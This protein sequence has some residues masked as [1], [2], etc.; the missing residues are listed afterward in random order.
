MRYKF[1]KDE[2]TSS[3]DAKNQIINVRKTRD[4]VKLVS[5]FYKVAPFPNYNGMETK[6]DLVQTIM[7][8][9]FMLELKKQIGYN[10]KI[11][12]VG[13][14][15]SQ[16][17]LALAIGTNNE[18]IAL[19]PT[20]ESLKLGHQFGKK[21]SIQNV[22]FLCADIFDDPIKKE[23][24]DLVWCSGVLHHTENPERGFDIIQNWAKPDGVIIVGLYNLYGRFWTILRQKIFKFLG[25]KNFAARV[26]NLLDPY[27]RTEISDEKR[28]AWIRDQYMHPVESLHTI[29][30]VIG[31][32]DKNDV[33]FIGSLPDANFDGDFLG[34]ENMTLNKG[35][36]LRRLFAQI[37]MLFSSFGREG[38]LFIVIGRKRS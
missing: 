22:R 38:G 6:A 5:S 36:R 18:V 7:S 3:T 17:S 24:F 37:S 30:E 21:M 32:F 9:S 12:E 34:F 16:F 19:D 4:T 1:L 33:Q 13:S 14:G 27:L 35:T 28:A 23:S 25:A 20:I 26:I 2:V 8:N 11:I 15:T 31:W 29:D 10:K